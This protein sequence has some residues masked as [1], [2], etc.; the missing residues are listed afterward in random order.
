MFLARA[1]NFDL[2][3]Y[4][5][6]DIHNLNKSSKIEIKKITKLPKCPK[7]IR[8][9]PKDKYMSIG[10]QDGTVWVYLVN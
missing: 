8:V 3:L 5:F 1:D 4:D 7:S 9:S 2:N 10:L 6:V